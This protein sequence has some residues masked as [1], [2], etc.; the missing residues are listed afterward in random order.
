MKIRTILKLLLVGALMSLG[1]IACYPDGGL[2]SIEDYDV[3]ITRYN[4]EYNF[5]SVKTYAMPD[6]VIHVMIDT[7]ADDILT[8]EN[9]R[10]ILDQVAA[11]MERLEYQRI[12]VPG[13]NDPQPDVVMIVFASASKWQGYSWYPGWWG[14]WGYWPGWGPGYP[15]YGPGYPGAVVPYSFT[16]GSLF[17]EMVEPDNIDDDLKSIPIEW[18]AGINGLLEG[19]SASTRARITSRIDQAFNQSAYLGSN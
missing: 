12:D 16:T 11:N 4:P 1:M 3:V 17:I 9:D 8:R 10:L 7:T 18:A 14:Y 15:G 13:P 19:S 5:G 2:E 6:T